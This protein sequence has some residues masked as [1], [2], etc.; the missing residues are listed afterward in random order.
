MKKIKLFILK[1][2]PFCLQALDWQSKI[3][4]ENPKYRDIPLEII[5][6]NEQPE[7]AYS[8]NYYYVPS[9]YIGEIKIHEGVATREKIENIFEMA[10][11]EDE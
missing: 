10:I 3:L 5:D 4:A 11:D 2:C 6:E 8:Y 7:I 9:Y 1:N